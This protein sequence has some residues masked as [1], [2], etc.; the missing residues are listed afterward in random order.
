M[1]TEKITPEE[2]DEIGAAVGKALQEKW[3]ESLEAVC[4][5]VNVARPTAILQ[6]CDALE[7]KDEEIE[8][9]RKALKASESELKKTCYCCELLR[10]CH[11]PC[12]LNNVRE[13]NKAALKQKGHIPKE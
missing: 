3:D 4:D 11:L 2:L 8:T 6:M 10:N 1:S 12:R 5:Y 7:A 13:A 9:Y